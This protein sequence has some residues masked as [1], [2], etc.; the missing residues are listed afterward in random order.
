VDYST[1]G[2]F[3]VTIPDEDFVDSSASVTF[4][5]GESTKNIVVEVMGDVLAGGGTH[6]TADEY[7]LV[8]LD[9]PRNAAGDQAA[10]FLDAQGTVTVL[11]DEPAL[12]ISDVEIAEGDAG[13]SDLTFSVTVENNTDGTKGD[14]TVYWYTENN[15]AHDY[16]EAA[17]GDPDYISVPSDDPTMLVIP[18]GEPN[19]TFSVPVYGDTVLETDQVFVVRL[20]KGTVENAIIPDLDNRIGGFAYGIITNDDQKGGD[21]NTPQANDDNYTV[22]PDT[23]LTVTAPGV[24]SNDTDADG[25]PMTAVLNTGPSRGTLDLSLDGSFTYTPNPGFTGSDS[26]TYV[27]NDGTADSNVATV[28]ISVSPVASTMHVSNLDGSG[29]PVSKVKWDATVTI[30]VHDVNDDPVTAA[31]VS[32]RWSAGTSGTSSCISDV[33]GQCDVQKTRINKNSSSVTFTVTDV[34]HATNSYDSDAN[35]DPDGDS[36]GTSIVVYQALALHSAGHAGRD[37]LLTQSLNEETLNS[38]VQQAIGLWSVA[39][40]APSRLTV[41]DQ[42]D[43]HLANLEGTQLG[44][45]SGTSIWIDR[46]AAGY[47]WSNDSQGMDLLTVVTHEI[48]HTL[49]FDHSLNHHDVM[50]ANLD[51]GTRRLPGGA[52]PVLTDRTVFA[53]ITWS[54]LGEDDDD[55]KESD[56][57]N[58]EL[59]V[60]PPP[61]ADQPQRVSRA[62][63]ARLLNEATDEA[64][65]LIDDELLDLLAGLDV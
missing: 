36:D 61:T 39:D 23:T 2:Y 37:V 43:I 22:E 34:T 17:D 15:T 32:G 41:L 4:L 3:D 55:Q 30:T 58:V 49:G 21:Q 6:D 50:T 60:I 18:A 64:I 13:L 31:T 20:R 44:A 10:V 8:N 53:P 29:S 33:N 19:A 51:L 26:F 63:E 54:R 47:G 65:Q 7:F 57:A 9:N 45:A 16:G 12:Y 27:A 52:R 35:H 1:V 11:E 56:A 62:G 46:D 28:T 25:D 42:I 59:V 38:V 24:L 40:V 14:I 5:A 48:G